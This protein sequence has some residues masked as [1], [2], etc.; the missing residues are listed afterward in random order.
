MDAYLMSIKPKYAYKILAGEKKYELR[1]VVRSRIIEGSIVVLYASG[2]VK[3]IV[4]EFTAGKV[5]C[6]SPKYVW[7]IAYRE[8]S[9]VNREDWSYIAG[10]RE[11]MAIE[12][13]NPRMYKHSV[14]LED[15]RI[16][17]PWFNPPLSYRR[18]STIEPLYKLIIG[19]LRNP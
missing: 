7:S 14:K 2:R 17:M 10:S 9:G 15:L 6:G 3:A 19:L 1:R 8:G 11:A 5:F 4:G 12:V 18:L 13:V 16:I